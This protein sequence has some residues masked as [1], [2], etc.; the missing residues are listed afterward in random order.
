MFVYY[1]YLHELKFNILH[2]YFAIEGIWYLVVLNI[3]NAE[4]LCLQLN[5]TLPRTIGTANN[6]RIGSSD[7]THSFKDSFLR[8]STTTVVG[9]ALF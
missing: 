6:D 5:F 9:Y 7:K 4:E 1:N 8:I 3:K 2:N